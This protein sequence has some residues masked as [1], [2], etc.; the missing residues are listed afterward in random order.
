MIHDF[1]GEAMR[2][3]LNQLDK[4]P[5]YL[6]VNEKTMTF[7]DVTLANGDLDQLE[8][9]QC[10]G[11][12]EHWLRLQRKIERFAIDKSQEADSFQKAYLE[13]RDQIDQL[14]MKDQQLLAYYT[15]EITRQWDWLERQDPLTVMVIGM[16]LKADNA[17]EGR[18]VWPTHTDATLAVRCG[19]DMSGFSKLRIKVVDRY[20]RGGEPHRNLCVCEVNG[21]D[22]ILALGKSTEE[23]TKGKWIITTAYQ[24]QNAAFEKALRKLGYTGEQRDMRN[25]DISYFL[26]LY[27]KASQMAGNQKHPLWGKK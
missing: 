12:E 20:Y 24:S 13:A 16:A 10:Y 22:V 18:K 27:E 4:M 17:I 21:Q 19:I 3:K 1:R 26:G 11:E 6:L 23:G 8:L 9:M 2:R 15:E 5:I 14:P 7:L 25:K